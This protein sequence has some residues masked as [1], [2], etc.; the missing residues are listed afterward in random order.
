[1]T[2]EG[3]K[4][5]ARGALLAA[6][7][8]LCLSAVSAGSKAEPLTPYCKVRVLTDPAASI[9]RVPGIG[10]ATAANIIAYRETHAIT[11]IDDLANVR[12]MGEQRLAAAREF[13]ELK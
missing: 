10:E 13:M 11:S 5:F 6:L 3:P 1:M 9:S 8:A 4:S 2:N 7:S 12:G